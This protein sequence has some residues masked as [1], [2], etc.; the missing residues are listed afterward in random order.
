MLEDKVI[1]KQAKLTAKEKETNELKNRI[2]AL[3]KR[4]SDWE[5]FFLRFQSGGQALI[6]DNNKCKF[7]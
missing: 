1:E 7:H 2:A 5:S 3:E 4:L 6:N